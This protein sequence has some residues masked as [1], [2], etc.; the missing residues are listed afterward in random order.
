MR[1]LKTLNELIMLIRANA[2]LGYDIPSVDNIREETKEVYLK[3]FSTTNNKILYIPHKTKPD[4][5]L[6]YLKEKK[7]L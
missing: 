6:I 5:I 1:E 7:F 2:P 3:A 4:E